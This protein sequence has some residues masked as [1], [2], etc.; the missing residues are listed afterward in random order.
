MNSQRLWKLDSCA[1][2]L[3]GKLHATFRRDRGNR[4]GE[5]ALLAIGV[6][7]L[8]ATMLW[9]NFEYH[10]GY[11]PTRLMLCFTAGLGLLL[12]GVTFGSVRDF[13]RRER[14]QTMTLTA[15]RNSI[16]RSR[17]KRLSRYFTS[18]I[19]R[20]TTIDDLHLGGHFLCAVQRDGEI[21]PILNTRHYDPAGLAEFTAALRIALGASSPAV[22]TPRRGE[23][24]LG[25]YDRPLKVFHRLSLS[26]LA[27]IAAL[28][29]GTAISRGLQHGSAEIDWL[30]MLLFLGLLLLIA[31]A[32]RR[33]YRSTFL[34]VTPER[35]LQTW[36]S[37]DPLPIKDIVDIREH[38][39]HDV[40]LTRRLIA[41]H[42]RDGH[43]VGRAILPMS[44]IGDHLEH[45]AAE[46]RRRIGIVDEGIAS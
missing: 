15:D 23:P 38:L 42:V 3:R 37:R 39:L 29:S 40:H 5:A 30:P 11:L 4:W 9:M 25:H 33:G 28:V 45:D 31:L 17:R 19:E 2:D 32:F 21:A 43:L 1:I 46:L 27:I 14:D 16:V 18:P 8:A 20:V 34:I 35:T 7:A 10:L 13:C 24:T 12:I 22:S 36:G 6:G 26:V 44:I 41:W